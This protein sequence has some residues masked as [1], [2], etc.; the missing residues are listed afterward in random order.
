MDD[1]DNEKE[2]TINI[3]GYKICLFEWCELCEITL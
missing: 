3:K 1:Q 2:L